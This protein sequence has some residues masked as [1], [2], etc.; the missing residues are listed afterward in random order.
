MTISHY[1]GTE[2]TYG[3]LFCEYHARTGCRRMVV[4][5]RADVFL[6]CVSKKRLYRVFVFEIHILYIKIYQK[7]R[8]IYSQLIT[9]Y[10]F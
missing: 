4:S 10:V 5:S 9:I 3:V 6:Q 1:R 7:T 2:S 8:D